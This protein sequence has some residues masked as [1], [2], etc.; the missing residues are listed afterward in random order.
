MTGYRWL[1]TTDYIENAN[2]TRLA[3]A[4]GL[5]NIDELRARSVADP[6][7]YWGAVLDDLGIEF[8]TP[9][10][11]V[12]DLSRGIEHPDWFVG[13]ELNVVDAC[14]RRWRDSRS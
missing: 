8:A 5:N 6:A 7:W 14:L 10:T 12:L 3:R 13:A 1:P 9:H 11:A 2:V 4:H